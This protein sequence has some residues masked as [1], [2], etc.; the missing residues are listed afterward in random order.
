MSIMSYT[1]IGIGVLILILI[2]ISFLILMLLYFVFKNNFKKEILLE[3]LSRP[4]PKRV[5]AYF[6]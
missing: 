4:C 2:L 5:L 3:E 6:L 1:L